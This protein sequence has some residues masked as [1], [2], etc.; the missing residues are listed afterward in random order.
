M[1]T[2]TILRSKSGQQDSATYHTLMQTRF[3]TFDTSHAQ[4][5]S[6][7]KSQIPFKLSS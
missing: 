4:L 5:D 6:R 3:Q 2:V 7:N 1:Q